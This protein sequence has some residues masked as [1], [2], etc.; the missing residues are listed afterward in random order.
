MSTNGTKEPHC[1]SM[2]RTNRRV[3][4]AKEPSIHLLQETDY[5]AERDAAQLAEMDDIQRRE[6]LKAAW[7][8]RLGMSLGTSCLVPSSSS[9]S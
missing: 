1:D 8:T 9:D 3:T 6:L 4:F 2:D 7:A 5:S